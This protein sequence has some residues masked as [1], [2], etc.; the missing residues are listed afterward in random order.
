MVW[1][2]PPEE[3]G[4]SKRSVGDC[5]VYL[6]IWMTLTVGAVVQM[7][8][9]GAVGKQYIYFISC[10]FSYIYIIPSASW[11]SGRSEKWLDT[12][13]RLYKKCPMI[14]YFY[15]DTFCVFGRFIGSFIHLD[16][17]LGL[18]HTHTRISGHI[19]SNS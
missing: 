1:M 3:I 6:M 9:V 19:W 2:Y 5:V 14:F 12:H 18:M 8:R 4:I 13:R 15:N 7:E 10:C 11:G 17:R 16:T